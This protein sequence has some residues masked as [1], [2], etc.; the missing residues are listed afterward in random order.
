MHKTYHPGPR[1]YIYVSVYT[2]V[3]AYIWYIRMQWNIHTMT[4][5]SMGGER[6]NWHWSSQ[7]LRHARQPAKGEGA[8]TRLHRGAW[9][10][11]R[12]R[13]SWKVLFKLQN[14]LQSVLIWACP[15][16]FILGSCKESY[17]S[18][19][20]SRRCKGHR[21]SCHY[22]LNGKFVRWALN[23]IVC[24]VHIEDMSM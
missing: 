17:W 20:G 7:A 11:T 22:D 14:Y 1:S 9:H 18:G 2:C 16:W 12:T 4:W 13:T 5:S 8:C 6:L 15:W 21:K 24:L 23:V 3:D 10:N 19:Y